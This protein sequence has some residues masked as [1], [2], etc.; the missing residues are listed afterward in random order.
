MHPWRQVFQ[1]ERHPVLDVLRV[2]HVVVIEHQDDAGGH[3]V[4]L[5]E[6]RRKDPSDRL[7][8]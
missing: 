2:D 6:Q 8:W 3:R 7:L 4:E 1:Q 5:V